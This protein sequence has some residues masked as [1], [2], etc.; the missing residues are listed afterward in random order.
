M[1]RAILLA[2]LLGGCASSL[3]TSL[4][5]YTHLTFAKRTEPDKI[6]IYKAKPE[7]PHFELGALIGEKKE[8]SI[9][10]IIRAMRERASKLGG[11]ALFG[12]KTSH[13]VL[14]E[15]REGATIYL[16]ESRRH[17]GHARTGKSRSYKSPEVRAVVI[18]WTEEG[19]MP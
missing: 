14:S 9:E 4:V 16:G 10:E 13:T 19:G 12:I 6:E 5:P 1:I 17:H 3:K 2:V 18:R 7:R 15:G 11:D 8:G